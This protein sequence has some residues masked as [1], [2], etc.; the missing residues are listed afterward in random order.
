MF[1]GLNLRVI[2]VFPMV[3]SKHDVPFFLRPGKSAGLPFGKPGK[4][5]DGAVSSL[6]PRWD[7]CAG[8]PPAAARFLRR[9][10]S[11]SQLTQSRSSAPL[12]SALDQRHRPPRRQLNVLANLTHPATV[13][14]AGRP[15]NRGRPRFHPT[16]Q[17][18]NPYKW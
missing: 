4:Q 16:N 15:I 18:V 2:S 14:R 11:P 1:L 6:L 13:L 12:G 17:T 7:L 3:V 9:A 10:M 8:G 5:V